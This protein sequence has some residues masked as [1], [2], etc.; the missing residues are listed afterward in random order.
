MEG[1]D[2]IN[3]RIDEIRVNDYMGR[4]RQNTFMILQSRPQPEC[5]IKETFAK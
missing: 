1:W 4:S 3:R 2:K 5:L